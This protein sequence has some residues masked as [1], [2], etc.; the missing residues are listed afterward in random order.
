[1]TNAKANN[2]LDELPSIKTVKKNGK[3]IQLITDLPKSVKSAIDSFKNDNAESKKLADNATVSKRVVVE[4][5]SE[6]QDLYAQK[7]QHSKS[8]RLLGV[9]EEVTFT[10]VD[11]FSVG[12]ETQLKDLEKIAGK[13]FV[14]DHFQVTRTLQV[15]PEVMTDPKKLGKLVSILQNALGD[16]LGDYFVQDRTIGTK[17]GLDAAQYDLAEDKRT[18][19]LELIK[20]STG[21]LR[22]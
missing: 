19:L 11:K 5:V 18:E 6:L 21:G 17:K 3:D 10:R 20:Q 2:I 9:K 16:K 12:K 4:H 1:M 13:K 14:K 22:A 7:G 15:N 8:F